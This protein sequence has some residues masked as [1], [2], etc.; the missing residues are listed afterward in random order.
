M[1]LCYSRRPDIS[2]ESRPVETDYCRAICINS[3]YLECAASDVDTSYLDN[4][5]HPLSTQS[6]ISGLILAKRKRCFPRDTAMV[7]FE[8]DF[9]TVLLDLTG[10][11][12]PETLKG[13]RLIYIRYNNS[14]HGTCATV[15]LFAEEACVSY[16][17]KL[18]S[19]PT[20]LAVIK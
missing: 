11:D 1:K 2:R 8:N 12:G 9:N 5:P 10:W 20:A 18:R 4:L 19:L 17:F 13:V 6:V 15:I 7:F 16:H 3:F 14:Y